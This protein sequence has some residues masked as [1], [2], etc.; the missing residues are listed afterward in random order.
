MKDIKSFIVY[1]TA[2]LCTH[3]RILTTGVENGVWNSKTTSCESHQRYF[4]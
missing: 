2:D 3:T 4:F 1:W